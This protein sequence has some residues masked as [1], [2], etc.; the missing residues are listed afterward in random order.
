MAA[1]AT[2]RT[3][4]S[5]AICAT[6]ASTRYSKAPTRSCASSSPAIFCGSEGARRR[7]SNPP[8]SALGADPRRRGSAPKADPGGFERRR[9][10]PSLPQKMAGD[11]DAHDLV[12][13]F[14]YLVDAQVAQMALDREVLEAVSYTHLRAH[15]TGR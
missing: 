6:C 11:D 2:S 15:E 5:S 4:R 1:T 9:L 12:G 10:A 7:R 8:G 13:A 3:S 14:E